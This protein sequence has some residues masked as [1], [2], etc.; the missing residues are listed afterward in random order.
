MFE[1]QKAIYFTFFIYTFTSL[2]EKKEQRDNAWNML[3]R[4]LQYNRKSTIG[5][6]RET[7]KDVQIS[8]SDIQLST[9]ICGK[10]F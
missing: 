8:K 2:Q 1:D 10:P 4:H 6:K 3:P 5:R 9:L 7:I